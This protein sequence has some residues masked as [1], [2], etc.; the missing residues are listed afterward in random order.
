MAGG[1]DYLSQLL[2]WFSFFEES[3]FEH[4]MWRHRACF[5]VVRKLAAQTQKLAEGEVAF[6]DAMLNEQI[7]MVFQR[8]FWLTMKPV[9]VAIQGAVKP[10]TPLKGIPSFYSSPY[11]C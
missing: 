5:L 10:R 11:F 1:L 3:C 2:L 7:C 8:P 6:L 9:V 4:L